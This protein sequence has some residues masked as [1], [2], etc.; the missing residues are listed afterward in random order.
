M[1]GHFFACYFR[2]QPLK[3]PY[4]LPTEEELADTFINTKGELVVRRLLKPADPKAIE[5]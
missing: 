1:K 2:I 3:T 5:S 4:G